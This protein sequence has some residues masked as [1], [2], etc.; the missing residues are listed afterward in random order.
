MPTCLDAFLQWRAR[1]WLAAVL[2]GLLTFIAIGVPT[3]LIANPVFGRGVTQTDWA[4]SVLVVTSVL[5]G[6]LFATYVRNEPV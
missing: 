1:R 2:A 5:S 4:F 6:L 3:D